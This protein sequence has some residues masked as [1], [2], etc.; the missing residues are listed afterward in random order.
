[1]NL[2]IPILETRNLRRHDEAKEHRSLNMV[3]SKIGRVRSSVFEGFRDKWGV[4]DG[5]TRKDTGR[6]GCHGDLIV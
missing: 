1:M 3:V 2:L 4:G 6:E 5:N